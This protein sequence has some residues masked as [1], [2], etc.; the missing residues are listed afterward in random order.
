MKMYKKSDL[1]LV[2]GMLVTKDGDI[3]M[4]D[5]A[6][7][8]QANELETLSQKAKYLADQPEATPMPSLEGFKRASVSDKVIDDAKFE[9]TTP[10]IDIEAART[11]AIMDELDDIKTVDEANKM[12]AK[13]AD[14][15]AFVKADYMID[16]GVQGIIELF[17]MPTLGSILELTQKDITAVVAMA[18]GLQGDDDCA[19]CDDTDCV[20]HPVHDA[21]HIDCAGYVKVSNKEELEELFDKLG[22]IFDDNDEDDSEE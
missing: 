22:S 17:D 4:P 1:V 19:D 5:K 18:S 14:L 15:L 6:V 3:V 10:L 13:F 21:G 11:L 9:A 7:I 2:D 16:C 12:L 20:L 8:F